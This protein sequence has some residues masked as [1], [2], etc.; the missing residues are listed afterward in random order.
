[1]S[2]Y[3]RRGEGAGGAGTLRLLVG[4]NAGGVA[5]EDPAALFRKLES[6]GPGAGISAGAA[7][8][9]DLHWCANTLHAL[10]GSITAQSEGP[11]SGICFEILL[12]AE[13][14]GVAAAGPA[15]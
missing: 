7:A 5:P 1:M 13:E 4:A 8:G 6:A 11:A 2:A 9:A 3:H 14:A 15:A 10:G 12:P